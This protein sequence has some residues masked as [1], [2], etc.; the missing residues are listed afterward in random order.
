MVIGQTIVTT[1][2]LVVGSG[3]GGYVSAIRLAQLGYNVMIVDRTGELGGLCLHHGCIPSK[4]LIHAAEVFHNA[5]HSEKLGI[6]GSLSLDFSKTQTW[7]RGVIQRLSGGI[8][9]LCKQHGITVVKGEVS[10]QNATLH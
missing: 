2:V 8:A 7:K 9:G 10:F 4:A 5:Q 3:V 6:T 1:E